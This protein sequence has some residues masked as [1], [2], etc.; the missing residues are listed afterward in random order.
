MKHPRD[1]HLLPVPRFLMD[2]P[3]ADR[4]FS[5]TLDVI[6]HLNQ[7]GKVVILSDSD[8][9]FQPRKI[10]RSELFK[11]VGENVLVYIHK[12]QET[13]DV[14]RRYQTD[15]YVLVDG[16]LR[17]LT[18]IKTPWRTQ[19]TTVFQRQGHYARDPQILEHFSPADVS[20]THIGDVLS[21][22]PRALAGCGK[23]RFIHKM[24]LESSIW[25]GCQNRFRMLKKAVQ[26]GRSERRGEAYASVR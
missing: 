24:P 26:Q 9:V 11:I 1:P 3:F 17:I 20:I 13:G 23:T 22:D 6:T 25:R 16:K 8:V 4:L 14:E 19:V 15:H 12:E 10:E 5:D 21:Y 7:W 2:F 18:A